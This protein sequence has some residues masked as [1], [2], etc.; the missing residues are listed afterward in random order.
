MHFESNSPSATWAGVVFLKRPEL[1]IT[2]VA[3]NAASNDVTPR[4]KE[5]LSC[6][7]MSDHAVTDGSEVV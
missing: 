5:D 3:N 1:Q 2:L 6:I 7:A 4:G